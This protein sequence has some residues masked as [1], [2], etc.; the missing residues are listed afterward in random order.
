MAKS[1]TVHALIEIA[2]L[3]TPSARSVFSLEEKS[4]AAKDLR[5]RLNMQQ[6]GVTFD[7]DNS[8]Q[9]LTSVVM[10]TRKETDCATR[11]LLILCSRAMFGPR[12]G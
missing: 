10:T 1:I 7:A 9:E 11:L 5:V 6:V 3:P 2:L 8:S 4:V 12:G